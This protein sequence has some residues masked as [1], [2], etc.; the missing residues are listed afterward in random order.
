MDIRFDRFVIKDISKLMA[1]RPLLASE[2]LRMER[3]SVSS[4]L[5]P[6]G[7]KS[8]WRSISKTI[9]VLLYSLN[10]DLQR[11]FPNM[12]CRRNVVSNECDAYPILSVTMVECHL[13]KHHGIYGCIITMI[14]ASFTPSSGDENIHHIKRSIGRAK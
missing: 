4:F 14:M 7:L 3:L 11:G 8:L 12:S 2:S 1:S 5:M 13:V 6:T 9:V 10:S